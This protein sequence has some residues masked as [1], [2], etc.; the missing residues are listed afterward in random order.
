MT[1]EGS[2]VRS[3]GRMRFTSSTTPMMLAPGCRWML[4]MT[5]GES[6][7]GSAS[8]AG[9]SLVAGSA[10]VAAVPIQAAW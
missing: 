1:L 8:V 3:C 4:T 10:G 5:A 7:A 2:E 6:E 9:E